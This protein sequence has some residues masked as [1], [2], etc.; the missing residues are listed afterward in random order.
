MIFDENSSIEEILKNNEIVEFK[1]KRLVL[2]SGSLSRFKIMK[3][4]GL[5]FLVIPSLVDEE[6]LKRE[7]GKVK[8]EEEAVKYVKMLSLAK[9]KWVKE[10]TKNAVIL[11]ADTVAFY[12]GEILEKPKDEV[13]ARRIFSALSDSVHVAI[14][15]VCIIDDKSIDNFFRI[16]KVKMLN[17]PKELQDILVKDKLTYTYAGGYCID[18]NLE[19][20]VIVEKKEFNNVLGLPIEDILVKLKEAGYDFSK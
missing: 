5:D 18:G 20:K 3:K 11:A 1:E 7:F 8:T 19:E 16:S 13:D 17:I 2:A 4:L 6:M 14:T 10:H 9:A 12:K 15:G